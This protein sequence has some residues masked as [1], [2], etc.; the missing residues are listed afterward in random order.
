[1]KPGREPKHHMHKIKVFGTVLVKSV[2]VAFLVRVF[3]HKLS[4]HLMSENG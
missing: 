4:Q 1:M 2:T 3:S